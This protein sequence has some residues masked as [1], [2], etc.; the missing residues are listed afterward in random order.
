MFDHRHYVPI[1]R[2]KQGEQFAL[3]DLYQDLFNSVKSHLTPLIELVP[4]D[5]TMEKINKI[6][7][8][9]KKLKEKAK[10]MRDYWGFFPFFVDLWNLN[11][12]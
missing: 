6:G 12:R 1:L 8:L 10:Q 5:F 2:W 7:G 11:H 9:G 4:S 3:R